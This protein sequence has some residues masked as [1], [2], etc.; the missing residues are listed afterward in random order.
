[1]IFSIYP[2]DKNE[3]RAEVLA[4]AAQC[5]EKLLFTSLHIPESENLKNYLAFLKECYEKDGFTFFADISPLALER[6]SLSIADV[7]TLKAF[8]IVGLRIDFGFSLDDMKKLAAGGLKIAI[9][10]S[11]VAE[12][13]VDE[14]KE[15][16][17][18]GW[19]NYYP[20]PETG[21][22]E[23]FFLAQSELFLSRGIP[24]YSFIPGEKSFRAP[25]HLGLPMLESQR[26][27]NTYRN[28]V[29]IKKLCPASEIVCAEGALYPRHSQWI[30]RYEQ[31]GALTIP[32]TFT[33]EAAAGRLLNN[34]F[35]VRVEETDCSWRLENTRSSA[36]P[37]QIIPAE[38]CAR[39]TLQMDLK[40]YGRY[41]GEIHIMTKDR[42]LNNLQARIA[43]IP[44]SYKAL[45]DFISGG[46][47]V[48]FEKV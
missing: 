18:I 8:G 6:L 29:E 14:L 20:R 43:E 33:D 32:L 48:Q 46:Q 36:E 17:L 28:F 3:T 10:A 39:G 45:V 41:Q 23:R 9:N 30:N 11:T 21:I 1:M 22:T 35:N 31:E 2:T 19:H 40:G 5:G 37:G 27:K 4:V 15:H 13:V 44:E 16:N 38:T 26:Y 42:P 7:G 24:V 47:R 25:L 34:T 12:A